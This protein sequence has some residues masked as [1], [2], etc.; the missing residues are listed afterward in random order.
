MA[1]GDRLQTLLEEKNISQKDFAKELKIAPTTLNGY[2]K[3]K[4]HPDFDTLKSMAIVLNVSTDYLLE[5]NN[6][7]SLSPREVALICNIRKMSIKQRRL[8]Y[9]M[10]DVFSEMNNNKK[11]CD[12]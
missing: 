6:E 12:N 10:S 3:N 5:Y 1:F 2:I 8:I 4:R 11:E 7:F 9:E